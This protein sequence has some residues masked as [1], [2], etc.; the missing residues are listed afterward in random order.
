M[1]EA[2]HMRA[3][4]S[5]A[6]SGI[7]KRDEERLTENNDNGNKPGVCPWEGVIQP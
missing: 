6:I 3:G 2:E 4:Y 5:M 7:T 1:H